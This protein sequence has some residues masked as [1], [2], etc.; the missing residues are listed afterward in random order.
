MT[1]RQRIERIVSG[2]GSDTTRYHLAAL[3]AATSDKLS[4]LSDEAMEQLARRMYGASLQERRIA[5]HNQRRA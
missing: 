5:E 4:L 2:F 3:M 1:R